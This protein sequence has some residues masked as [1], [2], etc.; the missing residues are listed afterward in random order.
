V[1]RVPSVNAKRFVR[2]MR[3]SAQAHLLECDDG[4]FYVVKFSNNPQGGRRVLDNEFVSSLL[5]KRLGI[6]TPEIAVV[7]LDY[8]FMKAN[9]KYSFPRDRIKRLRR[10]SDLISAPYTSAVPFLR[11]SSISCPGRSCRRL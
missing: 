4:S 1:Q 11:P 6:H 3:G 8:D 9:P 10:R 5:M 7:N 2:K